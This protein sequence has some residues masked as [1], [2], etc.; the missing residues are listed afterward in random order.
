M[1]RQAAISTPEE[2]R[3]WIV[4]ALVDAKAQDLCALDVR[5]VTILADYFLLATGTSS[6][7]IRSVGRAVKDRLKQEHG[8]N[9]QPE[10]NEDSNWVVLDY[11]DVVAHIFS[12]ETRE[13]YSLEKLW[14]KAVRLELNLPEDTERD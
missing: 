5:E 7:H 10:G 6:V 14:N 4:A 8:L 3:D 2:K 12:Q 13:F 11:G 9:C 1:T